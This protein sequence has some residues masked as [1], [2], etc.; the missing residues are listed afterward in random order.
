[1][2]SSALRVFIPNNSGS[3]LSRCLAPGEAKIEN[4]QASCQRVGGSTLAPA[5]TAHPRF[6]WWRRLGT[7][8]GRSSRFGVGRGRG[9]GRKGL[10]TARRRGS[11]EGFV[12]S[13]PWGGGCRG[14]RVDGHY[15]FSGHFG[16]RAHRGRDRG[17]ANGVPCLR[18]DPKESEVL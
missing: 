16:E 4:I 17:E 2:L 3:P 8:A 14:M 15:S 18:G 11:A 6:L 7:L 5:D 10:G 1:M 13:F 12:G 9:E